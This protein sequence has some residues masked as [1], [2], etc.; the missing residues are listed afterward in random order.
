MKLIIDKESNIPIYK[1]IALQFEDLIK[2]GVLKENDK[3][4]TEKELLK[5]NDIAKGT[6]KRAYSE[7]ENMYFVKKVQGS[8]TYVL[9][10]S[11]YNPI[12]KGE[13]LVQ[14]TFSKLF[15]MNLEEIYSMFS[16]ELAVKLKDRNI[17]NMAWID[18]SPE[19]LRVTEKQILKIPNL[20]VTQ[21]LI[22]DIARSKIL[23][24]D[25]Y[26]II[27]TTQSHYEELLKLLSNQSFGIEQLGLSVSDLTVVEIAKIPN[28]KTI[29]ILYESNHFLENIKDKLKML[30]KKNK[31]VGYKY[32]CNL[33]E[34]RR[35]ILE[36]GALLV[37]P[38]YE[39]TSNECILSMIGWYKE[40]NNKIIPFEYLIDMGSL[41][42]LEL[43]VQEFYE[44]KFGK[45][46][47]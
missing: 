40:N 16:K 11:E 22:D 18:C 6:V 15:F 47:V 33:D 8:G 35:G 37:P 7:L 19:V 10:N 46:N 41:F 17:V 32:N 5:A 25:S 20:N 2:S 39:S 21:F 1:Q 44:K 43:K 42:H 9:A 30:D 29:A 3:L 24:S 13:R 34:F 38:D 45:R 27:A 12:S 4:P 36:A 28:D 31:I 26:D 14:D 23:P